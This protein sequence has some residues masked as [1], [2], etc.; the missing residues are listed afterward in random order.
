MSKVKSNKRSTTLGV[1]SGQDLS[2]A[3]PIELVF[4][5]NGQCLV[6]PAL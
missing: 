2:K 1:T 4:L 6:V 3:V 5:S